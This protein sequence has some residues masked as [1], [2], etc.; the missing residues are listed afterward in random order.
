ML[1]LMYDPHLFILELHCFYFLS[2]CV[3]IFSLVSVL[4]PLNGSSAFILSF[5]PLQ[6]FTLLCI[7]LP[8]RFVKAF[9]T[10]HISTLSPFGVTQ[11]AAISIYRLLVDYCINL[12]VTAQR[13]TAVDK[14]AC[15]GGMTAANKHA[16]THTSQSQKA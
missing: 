3:L 14:R 1:S 2:L 13:C 15:E 11:L 6:S 4:S 9:Q 8:T 5:H 16:N 7:F 12:P 10:F